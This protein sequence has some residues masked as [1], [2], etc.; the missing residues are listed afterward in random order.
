VAG[1]TDSDRLGEC[2]PSSEFAE[3]PAS[4]LR[5]SACPQNFA[6]LEYGSESGGPGPRNFKSTRIET[7]FE[8]IVTRTHGSRC[9]PVEDALLAGGGLMSRDDYSLTLAIA[10]F[11]QGLTDIL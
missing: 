10:C 2:G 3:S 4:R 5:V 9:C 1:V 6:A 7:E 8:G 11:F